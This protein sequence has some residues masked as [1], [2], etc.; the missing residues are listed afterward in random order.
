MKIHYQ[1]IFIAC[2]FMC[3]YA[4]SST[5][6]LDSWKAEPSVV[7]LFKTKKVLVI[8][9]TANDDA[10]YAF[11]SALTRCFAKT[12]NQRHREL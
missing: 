11:E 2:S 4:C 5:K 7:E 8:A 9:R 3:L 10:R 1:I 6:I 12:G